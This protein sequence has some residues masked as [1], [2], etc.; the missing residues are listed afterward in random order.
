MISGP[1]LD[2][3]TGM[4]DLSVQGFSSPTTS[5]SLS[6]LERLGDL[7]LAAAAAA[8]EVDV[9][10]L[11]GPD[12]KDCRVVRSSNVGTLESEVRGVKNGLEDQKFDGPGVGDS[13]GRTPDV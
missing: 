13:H 6:W 12:T 10:V 4:G 7:L 11:E 2:D 1:E 3:S 8:V 9:W 5:R